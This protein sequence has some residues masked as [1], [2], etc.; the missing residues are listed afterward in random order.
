[1]TTANEH[2]RRAQKPQRSYDMGTYPITKEDKVKFDLWF[3]SHIESLPEPSSNE[4]EEMGVIP[5]F[6]Y[7]AVEIFGHTT[8]L[9]SAFHKRL[10][11]PLRLTD[12]MISI[13]YS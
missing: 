13:E 6:P 10:C 8:D 9:P 7:K 11:Y 2:V 5:S 1:M 4:A 3:A 12:I